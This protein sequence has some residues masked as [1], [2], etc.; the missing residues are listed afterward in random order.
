MDQVFEPLDPAAQQAGWCRLGLRLRSGQGR[1]Q[2]EPRTVELAAVELVAIE[3]VAIELVAIELVAIELVAIELVPVE[4]VPVELATAGVGAVEPPTVDLPALVVELRWR[5]SARR[6]PLRCW[7][8]A[9]VRQ[10][11]VTRHASCADL[12]S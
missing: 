7:H 12:D 9:S 6:L 2:V 4:V 10:M 11:W 5:G 3:L 1:R 8:D